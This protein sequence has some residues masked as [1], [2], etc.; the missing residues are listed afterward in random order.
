MK[1]MFKSN[2]GYSLIE[3]GVGILILTVFLLVSLGLFNGAYN[4]YRRIK[5]RNI[6]VNAAVTQ[7]ETMLQ[8]DTAELTG[9]FE[10]K[11]NNITGKYELRP[12]DK[13][14]E[15]IDDDS[16]SGDVEQYIKDNMSK[17]INSYIKNVVTSGDDLPTD[18][19]L[20]NGEYGFIIDGQ[21]SNKNEV[22]IYSASTVDGVEYVASNN[23]PLKIVKTV[24]RLPV[25]NGMIYG[26]EVLKLKVEVFYSDKF[27]NNLKDEDMQSI[28]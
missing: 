22:T 12:C 3:I 18:Q 11:Q 15:F 16:I 10:Q 21:D 4:N 17:C 9:F 13:L 27:G 24:R 2:K 26:N 7:I 6:A 20:E 28:V 5:Q 14:V 1:C 19:E 25:Q 23:Q 8:M